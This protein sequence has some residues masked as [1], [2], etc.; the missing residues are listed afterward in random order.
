MSV[1]SGAA[2][3]G[4]PAPELP[5]S[6]FRPRS[7][8]HF[9][10]SLFTSMGIKYSIPLLPKRRRFRTKMKKY[11]RHVIYWQKSDAGVSEQI[12]KIPLVTMR[13]NYD[14][15]QRASRTSRTSEAGRRGGPRSGASRSYKLILLILIIS[16]RV[17]THINLCLLKHETR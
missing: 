2:R 3:E 4:R 10:V 11:F 14:V 13:L 17:L 16:C 1:P 12:P 5:F 8:S 6:L 7:N 15:Q 9:F